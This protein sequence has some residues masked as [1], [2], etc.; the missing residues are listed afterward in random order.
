L[1]FNSAV[2]KTLTVLGLTNDQCVHVNRYN[3]DFTL[4]ELRRV[5]KNEYV[6]KKQE[7]TF[8]IFRNC[9]S[10]YYSRENSIKLVFKKII[11]MKW[12][13]WKCVRL[14]SS[15]STFLEVIAL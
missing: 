7:L 2:I 12:I 14:G 5:S 1:I 11:P 8:R 4:K 3:W 13:K 15:G 6:R 10:D 9:R